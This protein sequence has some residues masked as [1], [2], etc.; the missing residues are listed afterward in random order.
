MP[1]TP[2]YPLKLRATLHAKVWGGR[3][4]G[5]MLGFALPDDQPY[6]EAWLLHDSC[7]VANGALAGITLGELAATLGE[8]LLGKGNDP[9][10][11]MPLLAKF[12][13]ASQWLSVQAH[14]DD[15]MARAL[16][17]EPRGKTEAWIALHAEPGAKLVAGF[18]SGAT[19]EQV[20]DAIERGA[21]E[22]LL[23]Y[24]NVAVG[25]AL[26]IPAGTV[27]ALGPGLLIYEIQQSSDR[28][29]RLYDWGRLGLDGQPRDLHI[30]KGLAAADPE[31]RPGVI[32][33]SS[34]TIIE[35]Q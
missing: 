20:A 8:D 14:P 17:D 32:R 10:E 33:A 5:Q 18:Q 9:R 22:N 3:R 31:S 11:G 16:E 6:G 28:T 21:L 2:L 34:E 13:D 19:R 26:Y 30:D 15:A 1:P 23:R 24:V 4:L 35:G 7:V 12:I 29:Y 25:D 27:H